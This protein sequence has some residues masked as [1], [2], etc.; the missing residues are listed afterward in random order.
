MCRDGSFGRVVLLGSAETLREIESVL[1]PAIAERVVGA[2]PVDLHADDRTLLEQAHALYFDEERESEERLWERIRSEYLRGG[3]AAAGPEEVLKAATTGRVEAMI[4]AR[5]A[6]IVGTR[7]R[8]CEN[9]AA[10][11][12]EACPTCGSGS[13]FALDLVD[14]LA[15]QL[16]LTSATAEFSDPIPALSELGGVAALLRY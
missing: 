5:D 10:V 11:R 9:V 14:E 1:P 12:V 7:C 3:L 4:V 15:R 13:V 6:R 16:E 8:D 2:K